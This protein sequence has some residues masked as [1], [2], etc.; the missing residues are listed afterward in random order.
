M[1]KEQQK[2]LQEKQK[3]S[4]NKLKSDGFTDMIA[5]ETKEEGLELN[6][7]VQSVPMDDSGKSSALL[8]SSK[9]RP[10][11]PPG[12]KSTK[13]ISSID[14]EVNI[15]KSLSNIFPKGTC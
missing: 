5:E 13:P 11:V 10:L 1:R 12:F 15:L 8:Q 7:A 14:K 6:S 2:V 4:G 9:P 3:S